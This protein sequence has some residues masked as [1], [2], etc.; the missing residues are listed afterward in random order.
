MG[1]VIMYLSNLQ[2]GKHYEHGESY[3]WN[4]SFPQNVTFALLPSIVHTRF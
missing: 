1:F 4:N 2:L 3:F